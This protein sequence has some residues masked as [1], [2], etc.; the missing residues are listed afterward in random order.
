M[1]LEL[2]NVPEVEA[3]EILL[4]S[5]GGYVLAPRR[6]DTA[7]ASRYDRILILPPSAAA[8][9]RHGWCGA[10][11][12]SQPRPFATPQPGSSPF[13]SRRT[14]TTTPRRNDRLLRIPRSNRASAG[15]QHVP[16]GRST[17]DR[18][19][20]A[21]AAPTYSVTAP[22]ALPFLEWSSRR[23]NPRGRQGRRVAQQQQR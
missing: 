12:T 4:R 10:A 15:L 11:S 19:A 7:N 14:T 17:A 5:A 20:A 8:S 2:T 23:H 22:W 13:S 18:S 16:A 21:P 9:A 1:T 6:A 3:L